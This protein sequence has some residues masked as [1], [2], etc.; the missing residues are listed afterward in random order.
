MHGGHTAR[1]SDF[2]WNRNDPWVM[3][4]AAEDNLIQVWRASRH[5]VERVGME[6]DLANVWLVSGNPFDIVGARAY[7]LN[8]I[9]VNRKEQRG[10]EDGLV[11]G[12]KGRPTEIV[13]K[14]DEVVATAMNNA[15]DLDGQWNEF[16]GD[17][18]P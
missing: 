7:G 3:V 14:L 18:K 2:D 8:A 1:V 15:A 5:L 10:W 4:S 12:E 9:W 11:E 13:T 17:R 6:N 16:H